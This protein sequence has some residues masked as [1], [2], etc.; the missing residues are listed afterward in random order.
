MAA[1]GNSQREITRRYKY[2][3][4]LMNSEKAAWRTRASRK[5]RHN[6]K[7][8]LNTAPD[9]DALALPLPPKTRGWLW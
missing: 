2:W 3:R 4:W 8:M 6:A 5:Y 7:R 9:F 1:G